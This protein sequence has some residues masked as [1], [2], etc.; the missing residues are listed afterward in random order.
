MASAGS[1]GASPSRLAWPNVIGRAKLLQSRDGLRRLGRSL[2]LP[3]S[4][5]ASRAMTRRDNAMPDGVA[6][7]LYDLVGSLAPCRCGNRIIGLSDDRFREIV[8]WSSTNRGSTPGFVRFRSRR[9]RSWGTH[10]NR[11]GVPEGRRTL[12]DR[13]A[14]SELTCARTWR[15]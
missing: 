5:K 14:V 8:A 15:R 12:L 2:A 11:R 3:Q 6:Q 9:S 1:D 10:Q 13:A 7:V 4:R